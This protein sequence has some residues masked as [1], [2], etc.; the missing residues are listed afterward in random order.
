[1]KLILIILTL[2]ITSCSSKWTNEKNTL[3]LKDAKENFEILNT[4]QIDQTKYSAR[5]ALGK[6]LYFEK[7]L[8]ANGT[9]SCNSCHN[10]ENYGVDNEP[11]SPGFNGT[12]GGRNSPTV[13]NSAIHLA[14]FWDGRAKDVE[15][16]ALG[17]LLN[18]IEHGLKNKQQTMN[19]L[20]TAGYVPLFKNAFKGYKYP[21]TFK[22]I[23]RAIGAYEKTLMTPSRFDEFLSGDFSALTSLE[24]RGLSKFIE[25]GCVNCHNGMGIGGE[26]YQKLGLEVPY[27]TKDKGR[28]EVTKDEDDLHVFKV[29]SLR[30]VT[31]TH[32][33]FHDGH[34]KNLTSAIKIMGKHQ[35]NVKLSNR[36]VSD[37]KTFLHSLTAKELKF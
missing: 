37:I 32:P 19:I 29:P 35:L 7:K 1:M 36:D 30:N 2:S 10:L 4:N 25:V 6:K 18:P 22:N 3:L 20:K 14:Q 26:T 33:Y 21:F 13:Y 15:E 23:G 11:T 8:S 28:Y 34:I 17:P 27:P 24:K 5:I 12:R 31:K 9:L 16:Q